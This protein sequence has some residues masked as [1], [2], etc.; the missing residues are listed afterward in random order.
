MGNADTLTFSLQKPVSPAALLSLRSDALGAL[1]GGVSEFAID[2]DDVGILDSHVI[3]TLIAILRDVRERGAAIE[4]RASRKSILDTL[5]ITALDKV[6]TISEPSARRVPAAPLPPRKTAQRRGRLV[7]SV[8]A[9]A[10]AAASLIGSRGT[11]VTV[12]V[13]PAKLQGSESVPR[14]DRS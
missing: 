1:E 9:G 3:S 14:R 7:A 12:K 4:L 2:I 10:F 13:S 11:Q 5:R 6:F 8:A